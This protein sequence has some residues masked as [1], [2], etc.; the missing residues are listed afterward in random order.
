MNNKGLAFRIFLCCL[1]FDFIFKQFSLAQV[2]TNIVI[3][4]FVMA[5]IDIYHAIFDK[6][7]EKKN[8]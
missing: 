8:E 6:K 3:I 2:L 1:L 5:L 4:A 7:E